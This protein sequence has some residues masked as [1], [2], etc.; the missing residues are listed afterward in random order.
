MGS[1]WGRPWGFDTPLCQAVSR[2]KRPAPR[3][4]PG[5]MG[6]TQHPLPCRYLTSAWELWVVCPHLPSVPAQGP[7]GATACC[8][9]G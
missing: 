4:D 1:G 7:V 8:G 2:A 3:C 9:Q 5:A 6:E